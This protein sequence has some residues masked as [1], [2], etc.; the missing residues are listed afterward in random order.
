MLQVVAS[1][2]RHGTSLLAPLSVLSPVIV[3]RK[4]GTRRVSKSNLRHAST[5]GDTAGQQPL[6]TA[7]YD[8][9]VSRGAKMVEFAGF[10]MP[11]QYSDLGI[12]DSH[13]HTRAHCSL[14]DVS[15]M[16]QTRVVGE[17]RVKFMESLTV[18]DVDELDDGCGTLTLFTN[19]RGGVVDDLI[20][21]KVKGTVTL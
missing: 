9:H 21:N 5:N 20:C 16:V 2:C 4:C 19:A 12:A 10:M 15:H 6:R 7:L 14:F 11:L 17:D 1:L 8:F 18:A 13:R 3:N